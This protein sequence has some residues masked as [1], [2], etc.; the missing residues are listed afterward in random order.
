VADIETFRE[1]TRRWL[2]AEAP[3]SLR[4]WPVAFL[5]GIWGGRKAHFETPDHERW[6]RM[7]AERG[8]TAPT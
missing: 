1:E 5:Q 8:W 4:G 3:T 6:L 7:M 2:E